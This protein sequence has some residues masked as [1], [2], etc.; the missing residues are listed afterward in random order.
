[1]DNDFPTVMANE[2]V[3]FLQQYLR[4]K[5]MYSQ[6]GTDIPDFS[7]ETGYEQDRGGPLISQTSFD[8]NKRGGSLGGR[9]G[10]QLLRIHDSGIDNQQLQNE[11][12]LRQ[13]LPTGLQLPTV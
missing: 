7:T 3:G 13:L 12:K 11:L 1:M 9:S 2:P 4:G 10:E 5:N 8:I 6:S